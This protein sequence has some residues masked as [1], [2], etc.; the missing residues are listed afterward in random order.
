M[1]LVV[2]RLKRNSPARE[3]LEVVEAKSVGAF[4]LMLMAVAA[5]CCYKACY[6]AAAGSVRVRSTV[7]TTPL[8]QFPAFVCFPTS[9]EVC[10]RYVAANHNRFPCRPKHCGRHVERHVGGFDDFRG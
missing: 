10:A 2:D 6:G 8:G 7:K 9:V 5:L 4:M 1:V 3:G